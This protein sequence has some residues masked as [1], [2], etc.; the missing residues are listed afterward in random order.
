[1]RHWNQ[2]QLFLTLNEYDYWG[3]R[4]ADKSYEILPINLLLILNSAPLEKVYYYCLFF[5]ICLATHYFGNNFA[6]LCCDINNVEEILKSCTS[7]EMQEFRELPSIAN[8]LKGK[9]C[10]DDKNFKVFTNNYL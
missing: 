1:M 2:F 3:T 4:Y 8:C 5:Q 9:Q 6:S 10:L 7:E